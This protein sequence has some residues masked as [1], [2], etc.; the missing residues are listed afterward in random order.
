MI[1]QVVVVR[2]DIFKNCRRGKE[3]AQVA[4][5][6]LAFLTRRIAK[7]LEYE[8]GKIIYIDKINPTNPLA[9]PVK[10][11][12]TFLGGRD[13]KKIK[14]MF[15]KE[16]L[17]W[18]VEVPGEKSFAKIVLQ[19]ESEEELVEIYEKAKAAKLEAHLITDS[20]ATEFHGV[21]TKTCVGIGPDQAEKIDEIT[22]HLKLR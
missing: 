11:P 17:E 14:D 13:P 16:E 9:P 12:S 1:K 22:G 18:M 7:Q 21:P 4:H 20:G 6:S 5:A 2:A 10:V 19:V 3:D 15:S 8:R